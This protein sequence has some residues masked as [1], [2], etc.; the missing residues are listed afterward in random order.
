M[1]MDGVM[2]GFMAREL[3]DRLSGGRVDKIAQPERDEILLTIRNKGENH[4]LL[5]TAAANGAR[6]H[7]TREK[8]N[9]P[10]EPPTFCMLMRKHILGARVLEI[11]QY[12]G[13]RIAEIDFEAL[14]EMGD[15]T[16]RTLICEFMGKYSNL[17]LVQQSGRIIEDITR[18]MEGGFPDAG[19]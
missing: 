1:P 19:N 13:D 4:M 16:V 15:Y 17:I 12:A 7:L 3:N 18:K 14:D 5:I 2:L 9:N 8:K 11:R 6:M 10:L